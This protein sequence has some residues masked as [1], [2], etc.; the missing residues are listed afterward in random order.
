MEHELELNKLN[1]SEKG[2]RK[3]K[4][5]HPIRLLNEMNKLVNNT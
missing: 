5:M 3:E 2:V 4:T 1:E